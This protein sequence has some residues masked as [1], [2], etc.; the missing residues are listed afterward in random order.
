MIKRKIK[1]VQTSFATEELGS[2]K[3]LRQ[4]TKKPPM[5]GLH[6]A[7]EDSPMLLNEDGQ[8][9]YAV[10]KA[11]AKGGMTTDEKTKLEKI[12]DVL[13]DASIQLTKNGAIII[14]NTGK[15]IKVRGG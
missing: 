13:K 11:F 3:E 5:S 8:I 12:D 1:F 10:Y 4:D 14:D 15:T 9:L 2:K 6:H 7:I